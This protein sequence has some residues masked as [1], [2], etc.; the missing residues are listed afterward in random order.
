MLINFFTQCNPALGVSVPLH[1][2]LSIVNDTTPQG[3]RPTTRAILMPR[4]SRGTVKESVG[5]SLTGKAVDRLVS[6]YLRAWPHWHSRMGYGAGVLQEAG[7]HDIRLIIW[8]ALVR[9]MVISMTS[10][11]TPLV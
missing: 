10:Y 4:T 2:C 5:P 8:C 7:Y 6:P 11:S 1:A 9:T 3:H